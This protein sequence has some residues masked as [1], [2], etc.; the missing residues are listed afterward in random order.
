SEG[1]A[2]THQAIVGDRL[3]LP[4]D[5]VLARAV[6]GRAPLAH[7]AFVWDVAIGQSTVATHHVKA[8]LFYRHLRFHRLPAIGDTISTRTQVVGLR[9]NRRKKDRAPTGL[10]A[11]RIVTTDQEDRV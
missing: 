6:T 5:D 4:L 8:N 1:R 9:E 11:L 3:R 10:V 7:P 2:A